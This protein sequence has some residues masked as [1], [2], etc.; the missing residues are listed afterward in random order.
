MPNTGAFR[1]LSVVGKASYRDE[2][3]EELRSVT[4]ECQGCS[5]EFTA[6]SPSSGLEQISRGV[7]LSC[8]KCCNR[9]AISGARFAS[10]MKR[11]D[12]GQSH[13]T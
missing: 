9:Q 8:P 10:L 1:L 11:L 3:L 5:A 13:E 7:V 12:T 2:I 6:T 4:A